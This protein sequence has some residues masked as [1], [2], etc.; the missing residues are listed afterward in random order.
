MRVS[1]SSAANEGKSTSILAGLRYKVW[2]AVFGAMKKVRDGLYIGNIRDTVAV[3]SAVEEEEKERPSSSPAAAVTHIL[4]LISQ[5]INPLQT[6]SPGS[7][8][9][10]LSQRTLFRH[11][12]LS[13][14][15]LLL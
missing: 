13:C 11:A 1:S 10:V 8:Q 5:E 12:H 7:F 6:L 9:T 3:L 4:L 2:R 14:V 15:L